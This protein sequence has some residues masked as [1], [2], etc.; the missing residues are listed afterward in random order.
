MKNCAQCGEPFEARGTR[1]YCTERC[2]RRAYSERR[3]ADG[4]MKEQYLKHKDKRVAWTK[5]NWRKYKGRYVRARECTACGAEFACDIDNGRTTCGD[6][7]CRSFTR[8]GSW[9]MCRLPLVVC[10]ACEAPRVWRQG[11]TPYCADCF[12][13]SRRRPR[14]ISRPRRL[15]IYVRDGWICQ[16]CHDPVDATLH[17]SDDWAASLDHI[18]PRSRGGDDTDA[19]LRLA[20][21][22]CNAVRGDETYYTEAD[23]AA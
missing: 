9:P 6:Q 16:L 15:A 5:A 7:L 22:W 12:T 11:G 19:N 2:A 8:T 14:W 21:R 18:V 10:P 4:R 1:K 17:H 23:L 3:I 13:P 20:H